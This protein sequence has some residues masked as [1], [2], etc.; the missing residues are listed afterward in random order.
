MVFIGT[1]AQDRLDVQQ[2]VQRYFRTMVARIE[3]ADLVP[4][5]AGRG[6]AV[7]HTLEL[8]LEKWQDKKKRNTS[9]T[10]R[11][12]SKTPDKLHETLANKWNTRFWLPFPGGFLLGTLLAINLLAAHGLKFKIRAERKEACNRSVA[13]R[14]WRGIMCALVVVS[15]QNGIGRKLI[16]KS[17]SIALDCD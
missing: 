4:N 9:S 8:I 7:W 11:K 13:D 14:T 17:V 12:R 2:A 6:V 5:F 15:E 1:L 10:T 3:P 16:R